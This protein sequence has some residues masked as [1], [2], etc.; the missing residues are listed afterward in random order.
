MN[1]ESNLEELEES[2]I[3]NILKLLVPEEILFVNYELPMRQN[4]KEKYVS[5]I[6]IENG[7][8]ELGVT[9]I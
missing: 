9:M 1:P 2:E 6:I 7:S 3:F 4:R 5:E 8:D